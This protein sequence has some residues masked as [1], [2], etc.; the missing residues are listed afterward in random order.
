[1]IDPTTPITSDG[2]QIHQSILLWLQSGGDFII[3]DQSVL[4]QSNWKSDTN[5]ERHIYETHIVLAPGVWCKFAIRL[6]HNTSLADIWCW[7]GYGHTGNGAPLFQRKEI[8][9]KATNESSG[10]S[11]HERILESEG[12]APALHGQGVTVVHAAF[13]FTQ[14]RFLPEEQVAP[15]ANSKMVPTDATQTGGNWPYMGVTFSKH[16][17]V[18][19]RRLFYSFGNYPGNMTNPQG[20]FVVEAQYP[21]VILHGGSHFH[22][23]TQKHW[24]N[25]TDMDEPWKDRSGRDVNGQR[26]YPPDDQHLMHNNLCQAFCDNPEDIGLRWLVESCAHKILL[27]ITGRDK[28]TTHDKAGQARARGRI[29][30]DLVWFWRALRVIDR[31]HPL[32]LELSKRWQDRHAMQVRS[33]KE[34]LKQYGKPWVWFEGPYYSIAEQGIWFW[35][36]LESHRMLVELGIPIPGDLA[37][38]MDEIAR[39]CFDGF[40]KRGDR[41]GIPYHL[42]PDGKEDGWSGS[43]NHFAWIAA[44]SCKI[45]SGE[46]QKLAELYALRHSIDQRFR[47]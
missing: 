28:G 21:D 26:F 10:A 44:T 30:S 9:L 13:D 29:L 15:R 7:V 46:E 17:L 18:T 25:Y 19:A 8:T 42:H 38:Q 16:D 41:W 37:H 22:G 39:F 34:D 20:S 2:F 36:L 45:K 14:S 23:D 24:I 6:S 40:T 1:M 47:S 4:Q 11:V 5:I 31:E 33:W 3:G 35:G 27:Q 43:G 12:G 32:M